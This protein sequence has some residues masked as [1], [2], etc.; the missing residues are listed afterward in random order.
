MQ[1]LAYMRNYT[2]RYVGFKPPRSFE[3][4]YV[5]SDGSD[6]VIICYGNPVI[7]W[8]W[9]GFAERTNHFYGNDVTRNN[10]R[11]FSDRVNQYWWNEMVPSH[12]LTL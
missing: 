11:L 5:S 12:A 6:V 4:Y 10:M 3:S 9:K 8:T 2:K 1:K 7:W